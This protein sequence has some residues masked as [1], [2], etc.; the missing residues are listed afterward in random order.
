MKHNLILIMV[1]VVAAAGAAFA[2]P[3]DPFNDRTP[4]VTVSTSD[5]QA[6][7]NYM[8]GTGVVQAVGDQ[9]QAGMWRVS[10]FPA[11][12]IPTIAAKLTPV[13]VN[14]VFGIWFGSDSG[15]ITRYEIFLTPAVA[16]EPAGVTFVNHKLTIFGR[17]GYVNNISVIDPMINPLAFGFYVEATVESAPA[18]TFYTVDGLNA[19]GIAGALAYRKPDSDTWAIAFETNGATDYQDFV[20]KVESIE[21]V[22]EPATMLLLGSGLIG[23]AGYGR[24]KFFKK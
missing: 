23:L 11:S 12:T 8:F 22:F 13:G 15:N 17:P 20:V 1:L 10:A 19:G 6:I 7:L 18:V 14:Q 16:P 5:L 24:K 9:Q 3:I 2:T 4:Q 21:P